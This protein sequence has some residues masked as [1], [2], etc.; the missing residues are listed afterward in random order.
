M[1]EDVDTGTVAAGAVANVAEAIKGIAFPA[2]KEDV[3]RFARE[4]GADPSV[5]ET[6]D[7]LPTDRRFENPVEL[8]DA[9]GDEIRK[10]EG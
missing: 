5:M 8:F 3:V 1:V 4:R 2:A 6:L 10:L 7:A 9:V